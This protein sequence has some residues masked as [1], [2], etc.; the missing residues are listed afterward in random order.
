MQL[1]C[2]DSIEVCP[3]LFLHLTFS[4]TLTFPLLFPSTFTHLSFSLFYYSLFYSHL[5]SYSRVI[6]LSF[7]LPP[8]PSNLLSLASSISL[9][10][11]S[12]YLHIHLMST[13]LLSSCISSCQAEEMGHNPLYLMLPAGIT[14]GFS[15]MLPMATI[16][17]A[18]A[19]AT[20][21]FQVKDMVR[22][23]EV[24]LSLSVKIRACNF[25]LQF[26]LNKTV[27]LLFLFFFHNNVYYYLFPY[28]LFSYVT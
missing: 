9:S 19:Y 14:C 27:Q 26:K 28:F 15:F 4:P 7:T 21:K 22:R 2:S 25:R 16:A 18:I 24:I 12:P 11:L 1:K 23:W 20:G 5:L 17:N 6:S 13:Y 10:F 8:S 3:I